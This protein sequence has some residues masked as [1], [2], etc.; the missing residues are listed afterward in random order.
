[1]FWKCSMLNTQY[2]IGCMLLNSVTVAQ[3]G[4]QDAPWGWKRSDRTS[5]QPGTEADQGTKRPQP[6]SHSTPPYLCPPS[7]KLRRASPL[8]KLNEG[9]SNDNLR[10][11]HMKNI[12][13]FC[14][15]AHIDHGKHTGRQA[16]ATKPTP[17]PNGKWWTRYWMIWTWKGRRNYD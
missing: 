7:L 16:A 1:M 5:K 12:R 9:V 17:S 3:E 15:I 13:N 8:A 6:Q 10:F 14:I 2:S 11:T 4:L